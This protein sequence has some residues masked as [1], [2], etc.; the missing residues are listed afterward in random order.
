[1]IIHYVGVHTIDSLGLLSVYTICKCTGNFTHRWKGGVGTADILVLDGPA[2]A[3]VLD[4]PA[5][6]LVL[7]GPATA[8]L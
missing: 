1:M 6:A 4:G 2:T 7:D 3:L 8:Q 5:T